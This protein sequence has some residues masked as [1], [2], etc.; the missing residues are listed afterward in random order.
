MGGHDVYVERREG[1][2][3]SLDAGIDA[4]SEFATFESF[5]LILRPSKDLIFYC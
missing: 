2:L 4:C 1:G 5:L 3:W